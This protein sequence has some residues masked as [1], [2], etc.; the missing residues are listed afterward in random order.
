MGLYLL[1]FSACLLILLVFYKLVLEKENMHMFKRFYLLGALVLAIVIPLVTFTQYV[2]PLDQTIS[3]STQD[4][5]ITN[6]IAVTETNTN[7]LPYIIWLIYTIGVL[8]FGFKFFRNLY[9]LNHKIKHNP[10][11]HYNKFTHVLLKDLI[12]PHTFFNYI[13]FNKSKF[14]ANDIPEE[15]FW[16]E[17]THANQKHSID[18]VFIEA[19]QVLLWFNPLIYII[20]HAIKLNHEFLADQSVLQ[21]GIKTNRYQEIIL[22]FSSSAAQPQLANAINYSL[23][24]KRFTVMKTQTTTRG[25]WLRSLILL[26]LLA[27]MLYSFSD[28]KVVEKT[29]I[30]SIDKYPSASSQETITNKINKNWFITIDGIKYYYTF[31]NKVSKYYNEKGEEIKLD[32]VKEYNKKYASYIDLKDSG[33]HYVHKAKEEKQAI[34]VVFSDLGGMY[35]R[36]SSK[37][38]AKVKRPISPIKPYIK[39]T[40]KNGKVVYKK[41]SELT[42]K[43][44][45]NMIV[46]PPPAKQQKVTKSQLKEYNKLAKKYNNMSKDEMRVKKSDVERLKYLYSIMNDAQKKDAEPFP[47]I[48]PP[49]PA[50]K[51]PMADKEV[52]AAMPPPP[53]IPADATPEQKAK[54]KKVIAKYAKKYPKSV[55][56]RKS[57]SG[58]M[59]EEV[60][61]PISMFPPPPPMPKNATPEQKRKYE[62]S[63]KKYKLAVAESKQKMARVREARS[64]ERAQLKEV[65]EQYAAQRKASQEVKLARVAEMKQRQENLKQEKLQ[66][67]VERGA[68]SEERRKELAKEKLRRVELR[69]VEM[70]Q[71]QEKLKQE[72]MQHVV[73]RQ[74]ISEERKAQLASVKLMEVKERQI[75]KEKRQVALLKE[76]LKH[77]EERKAMS[78]QKRE[79][80]AQ[81]K[82]SQEEK[83]YKLSLVDKSPV[84]NGCNNS[85]SEFEIRKCLS[86][87]FTNHFEK[88]LNLEII[89][90]VRSKADRKFVLVMFNIDKNGHLSSVRSSSKNEDLKKELGRIIELVPKLKPGIRKGEVVKT[91]YSVSINFET[92]N[93]II[94]GTS[95]VY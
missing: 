89:N 86:E 76:K 23:I 45:E 2:E 13:F 4:A 48:P 24:K 93:I 25:I 87:S 90:K 3:L 57:K 34:D 29:S 32:I 20:K 27:L 63:I 75:E 59:I 31:N 71:R 73:E 35:F 33:N 43:D 60:E 55:S 81:Q 9:L 38:K 46:P 7:Y 5:L 77:V 36:M 41:R 50:P 66:R 6:S 26:P 18:V 30:K 44:K 14:E 40:Y 70:E 17:Q 54:Y 1:K 42:E 64:T 95:S 62:E 56:R 15:V 78:E 69:Q 12:V 28:T 83:P 22:A 94:K 47:S 53:P 79:Y 82:A 58:E 39:I 88:N 67:V 37:D 65:K 61:V 8:L 92:D 74:A 52:E 21:K 80:A 11:Q 72:K 85:S 51:A 10:K 16:H 84:Y 91:K 19:L 68:I 49:P